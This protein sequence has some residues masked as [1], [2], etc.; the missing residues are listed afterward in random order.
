MNQEFFNPD[1]YKCWLT[2]NGTGQVSREKIPDQTKGY[3]ER[4]KEKEPKKEKKA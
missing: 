2:G 4:N 3:L 1:L